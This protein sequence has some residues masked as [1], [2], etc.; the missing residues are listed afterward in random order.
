MIPRQIEVPTAWRLNYII[1]NDQLLRTYIAL[2]EDRMKIYAI[3]EERYKRKLENNNNKHVKPCIFK[4]GD[5]VVHDNNASKAEYNM[6]RTLH[7]P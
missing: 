6:G 2:M 4:E 7:D 5:Y 3:N 1:D